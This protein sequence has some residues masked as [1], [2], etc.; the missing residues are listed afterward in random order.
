MMKKT[1]KFIRKSNRC[2][3]F[4][5]E[6]G[7]IAALKSNVFDKE[8]RNILS[9]KT[10]LSVGAKYLLQNNYF[11]TDEA[12]LFY[13]RIEHQTPNKML[14]CLL[15]E[16]KSFEKIEAEIQETTK[17]YS[18]ILIAIL[19]IKET[20][21]ARYSKEVYKLLATYVGK[22]KVI[23]PNSTVLID[24]EW[25]WLRLAGELLLE[26][27]GIEDIYSIQLNS[28]SWEVV[29]SIGVNFDNLTE[30]T[31]II[32]ICDK[33]GVKYYIDFNCEDNYIK[34]IGSQI[35]LNVV[36]DTMK[37]LKKPTDQALLSFYKVPSNWCNGCGNV[38]T[39]FPSSNWINVVEFHPCNNCTENKKCAD[40]PVNSL[41]NYKCKITNYSDECIIYRQLNKLLFDK[42]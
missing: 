39:Q 1:Y 32:E 23:I 42:G 12:Q 30:R 24:D 7:N 9:K 19:D 41:C 13:D 22:I 18:N 31:R 29:V 15:Q 14:Y 2:I 28:H 17:E 40:C 27:D 4:N 6:T 8:E 16:E 33:A 35:D 38:S 10:E 26:Y 21:S 20:I 3:V 37:L 5:S 34:K 36:S 25:I 11:E